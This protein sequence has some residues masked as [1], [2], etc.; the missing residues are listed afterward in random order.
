MSLSD[1]TNHALT[2]WGS[3][4]CAF[5]GLDGQTDYQHGLVAQT[6]A[7]AGLRFR[8]PE[9][10]VVTFGDGVVKSCRFGSDWFEVTT[11]AGAVRGCYIDA[12]HALFMGPVHIPL[13]KNNRRLTALSNGE[14]TLIASMG[15]LD[16]SLLEA[17]LDAAI[18]QR[19]HW[20]KAVQGSWQ[21]AA[22]WLALA[23]KCLPQLKSMVYAPEGQF[24]HRSTT[25]DR[26][27]HQAVWLWDSAFQAIGYRH[28]DP[29][30]AQDALDAVFDAQ[31]A[32]GQIAIAATPYSTAVQQPNRRC[33]RGRWKVSELIDDPSWL[34][35][36]LPRLAGYL[37]WIADH[38]AVG[39]VFGWVED[40]NEGWSVCDESGMDNS[41]AFQD[42]VLRAI[43]WPVFM[44]REYQAGKL[45]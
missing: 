24:R 14:R 29:K 23:T 20:V 12:H 13:A 45:K 4:Y 30:L 2:T 3:G 42:G 35:D 28:L 25:P 43:G 36:K 11:G 8:Q 33:W 17:D 31:L 38:R 10:I 1:T 34:A 27:P 6:T 41:R 16:A 26:W 44:A 5:S 22:P 18:A 15:H 7:E 32:D 40:G 37:Q 21:P 19:Q 9:D 39:D